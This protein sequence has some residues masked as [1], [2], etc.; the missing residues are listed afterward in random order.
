MFIVH[1]ENVQYIEIDRNS[2][3]LDHMPNPILSSRICGQLITNELRT[4]L[5]CFVEIHTGTRKIVFI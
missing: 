1:K 3:A 2:D 5:S 4:L